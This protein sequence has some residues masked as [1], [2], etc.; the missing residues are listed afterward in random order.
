MDRRNA[1]HGASKRWPEN[2]SS[3]PSLRTCELYGPTSKW[4]QVG[5][6]TFGEVFK[7]RDTET[8]DLVALK[9]IRM[10][11]EKEGF[12]ITAIREI[13][14]LRGMNHENI[15]DLREVVASQET[16]EEK[17]RGSVYIVFEFMD[18]DLMGLMDTAKMNFP[19]EM[20]KCFAKQL[21]SGLHYCHKRN[22]M[23][24]D[25][26]GANLL[27]TSKGIL[28]LGDFGL[29]RTFNDN[30]PNYKYTNRV[31]TLWY[32]PPE[33]L[34]GATKYGPEV[35][36]WGAGCIVA[37]LLLQK[38]LFPGRDERDQMDKVFSLCGSPSEQRWPGVSSLPYFRHLNP[39]PQYPDRLR[40]HLRSLDSCASDML[41]Q[42]LALDPPKRMSAKAA[43]DH[44]W[45]WKDPMPCPPER[46]AAF[47]YASSHEFITKK[48][49]NER[50]AN[51]GT[52]KCSH[53]NVRNQ[54]KDCSAAQNGERP[55]Q[56]QRSNDWRAP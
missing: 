35:D 5:E 2:D 52:G 32:R 16:K 23:H 8:N 43:L 38:P 42:L 44:D 50:K 31:V 37:E 34:L 46:L 49:R 20:V 41:C 1:S 54:C 29:S 7:A 17:G 33:L 11:N 26:K 22:I 39:E 15:I 55:H 13:K 9:K 48:R 18:H 6:G 25:I 56:R 40:Q 45:F 47:G 10:R 12:P 3:V 21:L 51:G 19:V 27:I 36:N 28:K 53:G 14:L 4:D 30:D 24:R